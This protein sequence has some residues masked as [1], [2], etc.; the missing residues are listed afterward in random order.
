MKPDRDVRDA[1]LMLVHACNDY[2]LRSLAIR[3]A[4]VAL[5][6]SSSGSRRKLTRLEVEAEV[7][8]A[9]KQNETMVERQ[10]KEVKA[11]L[12]GSGPFLDCLIKFANRHYLDHEKIRLS[13]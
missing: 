9:Y 11:A 4:I 1:I 2:Q 7:S 5:R 6:L 8:K 3:S 13:D 10:A 12:Q